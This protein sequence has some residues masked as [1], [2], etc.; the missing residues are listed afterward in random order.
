M[1][2]ERYLDILVLRDGDEVYLRIPTFSVQETNRAVIFGGAQ[3][4]APHR[5]VKQVFRQLHSEIYISNIIQ[6]GSPA[7]FF[8]LLPNTFITAVNEQE[9]ETLD[10]FLREV[11]KIPG[12]DYFTV[13][14]VDIKDTQSSITMRRNDHYVSILSS[15][16]QVSRCIPYFA[17]YTYML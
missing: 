17:Q 9:T 12:D 8:G 13:R 3:L 7:D 5:A 4:Q 14:I 1:Y 15:A 16:L 10:D 2:N 6:S 11:S